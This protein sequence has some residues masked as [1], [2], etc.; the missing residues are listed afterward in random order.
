MTIIIMT[1]MILI[2]FCFFVNMFFSL[3]IFGEDCLD[4]RQDHYEN[5]NTIAIVDASPISQFTVPVS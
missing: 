4:H 3:L 5:A 2:R 1:R